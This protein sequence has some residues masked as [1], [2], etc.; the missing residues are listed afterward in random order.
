ME[1]AHVGSEFVRLLAQVPAI[2]ARMASD[3]AFIQ[4]LVIISYESFARTL[5]PKRNDKGL[6][7]I[8][9][10]IEARLVTAGLAG[11]HK[12]N[13]CKRQLKKMDATVDYLDHFWSAQPDGRPTALFDRTDSLLAPLLFATMLLKPELLD[14][15]ADGTWEVPATVLE[16]LENLALEIRAGYNSATR[17]IAAVPRKV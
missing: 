12:P 2:G 17:A 14:A 8:G 16:S 3:C 1:R 4:T 11:W 15:Y 7:S 6:A 10:N 9:K 5:H 13:C